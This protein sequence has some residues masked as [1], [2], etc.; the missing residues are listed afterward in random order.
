MNENTLSKGFQITLYH[1]T[2][3]TR[4]HILFCNK[5]QLK[6]FYFLNTYYIIKAGVVSLHNR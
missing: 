5:K 2:H 1:H 3:Q 4:T 6:M